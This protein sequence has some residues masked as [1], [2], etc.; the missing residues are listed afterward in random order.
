MSYVSAL[1][2]LK[3]IYYRGTFSVAI[4]IAGLDYES[5]FIARLPLGN[6]TDYF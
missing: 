3:T 5:I 1:P 2:H 6:K 4:Y